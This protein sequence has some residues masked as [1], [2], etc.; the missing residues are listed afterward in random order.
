MAAKAGVGTGSGGSSGGSKGGKGESKDKTAGSLVSMLKEIFEPII[1][2]I[3]Q[4]AKLLALIL[5]I[6]AAIG[7]GL[8][9]LLA[10]LLVLALFAEGI[11]KALKPIGSMIG[12]LTDLIAAM[13]Q[14]FVNLLIPLFIPLIMILLPLVKMLNV[15]MKP[16][17]MI[18]MKVFSMVGKDLMAAVIS[19]LSGDYAGFVTNIM[20]ALSTVINEI[21][22]PLALGIVEVLKKMD[23]KIIA[24]M[25]VEAIRAMLPAI[26]A[27]LS[28]IWAGIKDIDLGG[29]SLG[30]LIT[31]FTNAM[32]IVQNLPTTIS[33]AVSEIMGSIS[34]K[35]DEVVGTITT[36]IDGVITSITT[37]IGTLVTDITALLQP[38]IDFVNLNFLDNNPILTWIVTTAE[39]IAGGDGET[40]KTNFETLFNL[41][42]SSITAVFNALKT[43]IFGILQSI[44]SKAI[45]AINKAKEALGLG[46]DKTKIGGGSEVRGGTSRTVSDFLMRPGQP[47]I[48]FSPSDTIMGVKDTS[49]L[50]GGGATVYNIIVNGNGERFIADMV[51]TQIE[52][53][54]SKASRSGSFQKG[55]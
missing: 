28:E 7:N 4:V 10:P 47:A 1:R 27:V 3:L 55:Y 43:T 6:V 52:A 53:V 36:K 34:T 26:Q 11:F 42:C 45:E 33:N 20:A 19:L 23:W 15:L 2:P 35:I 39:A 25:L 24:A 8:I 29:F 9:M 13:V 44:I 30:G 22:I 51:K 21:T 5:I 40:L 38:I 14:P 32:A 12:V 49:K 17:L 18:M 50:G 46:G 31:E 37:Q 48:S 16:F 54:N 41:I